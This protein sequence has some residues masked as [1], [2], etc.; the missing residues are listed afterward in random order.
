MSKGWDA[1]GNCA[2]RARMAVPSSWKT[3]GFTTHSSCSKDKHF[4]AAIATLPKATTSTRRSKDTVSHSCHRWTQL[5]PYACGTWGIRLT[6]HVHAW[7][8][9]FIRLYVCKFGHSKLSAQSTQRGRQEE[10]LE[11]GPGGSRLGRQLPRRRPV[12]IWI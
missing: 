4:C 1:N 2:N 11:V 6:D 10:A 3:S 7:L 8:R 9:T 12:E 5:R